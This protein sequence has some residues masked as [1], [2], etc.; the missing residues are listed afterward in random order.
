LVPVRVEHRVARMIKPLFKPPTLRF[1]HGP[2]HEFRRA[3][4]K[5]QRSS[6]LFVTHST[7]AFR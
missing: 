5:V 6:R 3:S 7:T 4:A 1:P 2:L